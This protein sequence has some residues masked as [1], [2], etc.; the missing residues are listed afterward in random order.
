MRPQTL[1]DVSSRGT[2]PRGEVAEL[3]IAPFHDS[4]YRDVGRVS[5]TVTF[6]VCLEG[7]PITEQWAVELRVRPEEGRFQYATVEPTSKGNSFIGMHDSASPFDVHE[8]GVAFIRGSEPLFPL[9]RTRVLQNGVGLLLHIPENE[10]R[11]EF[12]AI[13][14]AA[15]ALP[16]VRVFEFDVRD[17]VPVSR[18]PT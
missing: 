8:L 18:P 14:F 12:D 3:V 15:S 4:T 7:G 17:G 10:T 11:L 2:V 16:T 9:R 5:F 1:L 6:W 13:F